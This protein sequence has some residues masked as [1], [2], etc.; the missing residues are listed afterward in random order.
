[1]VKSKILSPVP[2]LPCM[3]DPLP[4]KSEGP[5]MFVGRGPYPPPWEGCQNRVL[6]WKQSGL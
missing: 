1:M 5:L 6:C 2:D 3:D 4:A